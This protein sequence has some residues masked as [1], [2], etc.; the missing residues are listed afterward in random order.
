MVHAFSPTL[1]WRKSHEKELVASG[2]LGCLLET[3]PSELPDED[4]LEP[5]DRLVRNQKVES[6]NPSGRTIF[7]RIHWDVTV[8]SSL[9]FSTMG[10]EGPMGI[11]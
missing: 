4:D 8:R 3:R 11:S 5:G 2:I 1:G 10:T 6:S 7:L 9:S